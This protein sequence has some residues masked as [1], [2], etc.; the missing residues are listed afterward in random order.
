MLYFLSKAFLAKKWNLKRIDESKVTIFV[1]PTLVLV[2]VIA[3]L[4]LFVY[5]NRPIVITD[6]T[7]YQNAMIFATNEKIEFLANGLENLYILVLHGLFFL[8]GNNPLV[9]VVFDICLYFCTLVMMLFSIRRLCGGLTATITIALLGFLPHM[10][11]LIFTMTPG[12]F[13]LFLFA[14]CLSFISKLM[15]SYRLGEEDAAAGTYLYSVFAGFML[16]LGIYLDLRMAVLLFLLPGVL[17]LKDNKDCRK[18][19]C[20]LTLLEYLG[21]VCGFVLGLWGG[22]YY[23]QN[24]LNFANSFLQYKSQYT[25]DKEWLIPSYEI[26]ANSYISLVILGF[27]ILSVWAFLFEKRNRI[28]IHS[29]G[30]LLLFAAEIF[31]LNLTPMEG[32]LTFYFALLASLGFTGMLIPFGAVYE[33]EA[34]AGKQEEA[35]NEETSAEPVIKNIEDIE[36]EEEES[37]VTVVN[38]MDDRVEEKIA[39]GM[40]LPNPLPVPKKRERKGMDYAKEIKEEDLHFDVEISDEDDFDIQL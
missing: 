14:A 24:G 11:Q 13:G 22:G 6:G 31:L 34:S 3:R 33:E 23:F 32:V 39:P 10:T 38:P 37:P 30:F 36:A 5:N 8:L 25:Y 35:E 17:F 26:T 9:G 21:A 19:L 1:L 20:I 29:F 28:T 18:S 16:G 4:I 7:F 15:E 40:P 2:G 12:V 27:M